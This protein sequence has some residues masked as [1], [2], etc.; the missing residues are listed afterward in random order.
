MSFGLSR[1]GGEVQTFARLRPSATKGA[2]GSLGRRVAYEVHHGQGH[3]DDEASSDEVGLIRCTLVVL[4]CIARGSTVLLRFC[5]RGRRRDSQ[6]LN[7]FSRTFLERYTYVERGL[8]GRAHTGHRLTA[9]TSIIRTFERKNKRTS[10]LVLYKLFVLHKNNSK[11]QER[12][13]T[14][15]KCFDLRLIREPFVR[16]ASI[17]IRVKSCTR[18]SYL[19][20]TGSCLMNIAVLCGTRHLTPIT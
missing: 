9:C 3:G 15:W 18:Y 16:G 20:C 6:Q 5:L 10:C 17:S 13:R 14:R 7:V 11:Q 19:S 2:S 4:V 8:G 1:G 12:T